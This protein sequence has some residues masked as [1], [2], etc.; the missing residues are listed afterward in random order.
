[1]VSALGRRLGALKRHTLGYDPVFAVNDV[2]AGLL[3]FPGTRGVRINDRT[4]WEPMIARYMA[5]LKR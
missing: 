2:F 3:P 5:C 4:G 1:M